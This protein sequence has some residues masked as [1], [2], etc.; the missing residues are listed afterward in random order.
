MSLVPLAAIN[1]TVNSTLHA[2][3]NAVRLERQPFVVAG[4][5]MLSTDEDAQRVIVTR[6]YDIGQS[7]LQMG[8]ERL[9]LTS[10]FQHVQVQTCATAADTVCVAQAMQQGRVVL[11]AP[12]NEIRGDVHDST[13][14]LPAAASRWAVH[15]AQNP[16]IDT[17]IEGS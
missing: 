14:L 6:I 17:V 5:V 7:A 16:E 8:S 15:W 11:P 10:N 9:T 13:V 4:D 2:V 3:W 12:V 1:S